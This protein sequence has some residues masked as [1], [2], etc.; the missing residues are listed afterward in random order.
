[1]FRIHSRWRP[2][3]SR[4]TSH[5]LKPATTDIGCTRITC[6]GSRVWRLQEASKSVIKPQPGEPWVSVTDTTSSQEKQPFRNS[7]LRTRLASD[8]NKQSS[9]LPPIPGNPTPREIPNREL[10][11]EILRWVLRD[12]SLRARIHRSRE[13]RRSRFVSTSK[14]PWLIL[15]WLARRLLCDVSGSHGSGEVNNKESVW[16]ST[17]VRSSPEIR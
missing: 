13:Q 16:S 14:I 12:P 10:L 11:Q 6:I 5:R 15:G 3:K 7:L 17:A 8:H 9:R 1:M 4:T 2:R